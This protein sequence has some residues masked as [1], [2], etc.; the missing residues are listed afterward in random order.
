MNFRIKFNTSGEFF[1]EIR[2]LNRQRSRQGLGL[3]VGPSRLSL[4]RPAA[5]FAAA[6]AILVAAIDAVDNDAVIVVRIRLRVPSAAAA[7]ASA[8]GFLFAAGTILVGGAGAAV[9]VVGQAAVFGE[10]GFVGGK[11][12]IIIVVEGILGKIVA[13]VLIWD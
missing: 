10:Q 11:R 3:I 12:G 8:G 13:R 4:P 6:V 9:G 5:R 1:H 7:T 2:E